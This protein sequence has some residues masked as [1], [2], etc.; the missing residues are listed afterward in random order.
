MATFLEI[1]NNVQQR[2]RETETT[3]VDTSDDSK[4]IGIFVN[5]AKREV[6]DAWDWIDLQSLVSIT[7]ASGTT[8]YTLTGTNR[9]TRIKTDPYRRD[10]VWNTTQQYRL[11][12]V[13]MDY[14][15]NEQLILN[16]NTGQV[17]YFALSGLSSGARTVELSPE[18]N[19]VE[20]IQFSCIIPQ[21]DLVA[22][23]DESTEIIVDPHSVELRAWAKAVSERGED[24]GM[25]F[26]EIMADYKQ[27][28]GDAISYDNARS[29]SESRWT[30]V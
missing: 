12:R 13:S 26:N 5:D 3:A 15:N 6:E 2:L 25:S 18:P 23:T 16:Q 9:R 27:A 11:Q 17:V 28:L 4:R 14:I 8:G 22:G 21:N 29:D 20:T 1:V 7:T 19:A 30:V 24:G 10:M